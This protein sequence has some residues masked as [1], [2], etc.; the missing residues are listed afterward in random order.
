VIEP[1]GT[2]FQLV[3]PNSE[4]YHFGDNSFQQIH[5]NIDDQLYVMV[6]RIWPDRLLRMLTKLAKYYELNIYTILPR[7]VLNGVFKFYPAI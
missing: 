5:I 3:N 7:E 2:F 6:I 4:T 1:V